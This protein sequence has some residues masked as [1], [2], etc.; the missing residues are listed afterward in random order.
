MRSDAGIGRRIY[1][2]IIFGASAIVAII[3]LLVI[4]Y[5]IF[6]F[7]LDDASGMGLLDR[8]RAPLG[9]LLATGLAAGYHFALWRRE[10]AEQVGA[11]TPVRTI[12]QVILVTGAHDPQPLQDS[13]EAA[14]GAS[15]TVWATATLGDHGASSSPEALVSALHG[16]TASRVLVLAGPG[17]R[18]EVLVLSDR[19]PGAA[20]AAH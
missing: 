4:G 6:E 15:V 16:I 18:L 9:L 2:V 1:L 19:P 17:N 20:A 11:P 3:T 14:T 5:R 13:I 10:R 8:M 7:V 12:G